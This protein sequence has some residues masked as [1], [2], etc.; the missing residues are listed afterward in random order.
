MYHQLQCIWSF[1]PIISLERVTELLFSDIFFEFLWSKSTR[2]STNLTISASTSAHNISLT[3]VTNTH[4]KQKKNETSVISEKLRSSEN[5]QR[6]RSGWYRAGLSAHSTSY[7]RIMLMSDVRG[8]E[9][10]DEEAFLMNSTPWQSHTP[11]APL[12]SPYSRL[13]LDGSLALIMSLGG[14]LTSTGEYSALVTGC[15]PQG[16]PRR[17]SP[18]IR[19]LFIEKFIMASF[20][21]IWSWSNGCP[22]TITALIWAS[23]FVVF[24]SL[25]SFY[26]SISFY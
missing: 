24:S 25:L 8:E 3:Q 6:T 17:A 15:A 12:P 11:G 16:L 7:G 2:K 20:G 23:S 22:I 14:W 18:P 5:Q 26:P 13:E 19:H 4:R 21:V 1:Q 9:E 10:E